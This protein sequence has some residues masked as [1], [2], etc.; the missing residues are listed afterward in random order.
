MEKFK[1]FLWF[2]FPAIAWLT[3]IF[4]Q[5]SISNISAP[6]LGFDFQD[7]FYH[8]IEYAI[9]GYLLRRA[10]VYQGNNY[11]QIHAGWLTIL[12]GSLYAI[13]DEIHQLFVPGRVAGID[14]TI[15]DIIGVTLV[16]FI[17]FIVRQIKQHRKQQSLAR[18]DHSG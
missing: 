14:D 4:I 5:S 8:V 6:D 3:A 7:K 10:L 18:I 13:S 11:L 12:Y 2:Q 17:Y 16:V 9:L 15:A 1:H